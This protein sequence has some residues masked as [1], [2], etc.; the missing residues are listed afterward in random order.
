M[1][2]SDNSDHEPGMELFEPGSAPHSGLSPEA[3]FLIARLP[4]ARHPLSP[5]P[6]SL[7]ALRALGSGLQHSSPV[8]GSSSSQL[9]REQGE[10]AAAAAEVI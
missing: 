9:P 2:N 6:H 7:A 5:R 3:D 1:S 8:R 10:D 4:P